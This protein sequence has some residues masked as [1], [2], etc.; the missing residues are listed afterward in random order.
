MS[1]ETGAHRVVVVGG[2]LL[3]LAC[4]FYLTEAGLPVVVLE[5][6]HVGGGASRYNAG[7]I[8][9]AV[10]PLPEPGMLGAVAR[11]MFRG[12]RALFVSPKQPTAAIRFF[13]GFARNCTATA[14]ARGEAALVGLNARSFDLYRDLQA[15]GIAAGLT[16]S[17]YLMCCSDAG[18]AQ[19]SR[20]HYERLPHLV[21]PPG[22]L[23]EGA[24]ITAAEPSLSRC[25]A[26]AF[27]RPRELWCD[28][29]PFVDMLAKALRDSGCEIVEGARV[30]AVHDTASGVE[31]HSSGGR[32][33]AMAAVVAAGVWSGEL[34]R[35]A[36]VRLGMQPGK[37]YSFSVQPQV[38]PRRVLYFPEA[39][40][41]ATPI[42]RRLRLS[43][44]MELD[45][46]T[47][48]FNGR[49]IEAM[50]RAVGPFLQGIDWNDRA[51]EWVGPRPM[52]PD[53]LPLI[54]RLPRSRH[55]F[56]AAGHN[57][58]GLTLAPATGRIIADMVTG[59]KPEMDLAPF[60][61]DRFS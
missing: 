49:R 60:A 18:V 26:A 27:M 50:V 48:R 12:D 45:G 57:M 43:G 16:D 38:L 9:S 36:G 22:P 8:V 34:C 51:G 35:A 19:A 25:V 37:G 6:G 53:G 29:A 52:T 13:L 56:V 17:G 58:L 61:V 5:R 42:G 59:Q 39:S 55:V 28:A 14:Y 3:G 32:Y 41:V 1:Y 46:T 44:T 30:T 21:S 47:E 15:R 10:S 31:V 2:G 4:A 40:V 20:R 7:L 23:L 11:S 33:R 54:G 24:A